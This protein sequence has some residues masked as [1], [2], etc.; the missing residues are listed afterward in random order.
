MSIAEEEDG[1]KTFRQKGVHDMS[2][3]D[4]QAVV[5]AAMATTDQDNKVYLTRLKERMDKCAA[6]PRASPPTSQSVSTETPC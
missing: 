6:A 3:Q 5:K 2:K 1:K 4:L